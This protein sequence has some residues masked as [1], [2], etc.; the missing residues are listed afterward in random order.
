MQVEGGVT[1]A[2]VQEE[3]GRKY[4]LSKNLHYNI[5]RVNIHS[6]SESSHVAHLETTG[7]DHTALMGVRLIKKVNCGKLA[8]FDVWLVNNSVL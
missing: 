7:R 5:L 6:R 2:T 8:M 4:K 1:T 3:G